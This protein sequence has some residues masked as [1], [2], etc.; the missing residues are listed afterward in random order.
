MRSPPSAAA[1]DFEDFLTQ[2]ARK[3]GKL[4]KGN[5]PDLNTAAKC[6]LHDWGR[7]R[8]PYFCLPPDDGSAPLPAEGKALQ[9]LPALAELPEELRAFKQDMRE[10][11]PHVAAAKRSLEQAEAGGDGSDVEEERE[12]DDDDDAHPAKRARGAGGEEE[13]GEE[14]EADDD[15]DEEESGEKR[16]ASPADGT[17]RQAAKRRRV[18][19][20]GG[21]AAPG[22]VHWEEVFDDQD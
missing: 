3:H 15:D 11:E 10:L 8:L 4:L 2:L 20:G 5:E 7:G 21:A 22:G 13:S 18:G 9:A 14:E 12:D 1:Q 19:G 16:G 6:V 17:G